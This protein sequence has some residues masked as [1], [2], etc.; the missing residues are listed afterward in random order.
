VCLIVIIDLNP[1]LRRLHFQRFVSE[2]QI[3]ESGYAGIM[4]FYF[5]GHVYAP[6][7]VGLS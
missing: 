1:S 5:S 4:S 3:G 2:E 7:S 6:E